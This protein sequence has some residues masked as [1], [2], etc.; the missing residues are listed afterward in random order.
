[1][2]RTLW[3]GALCL[4]AACSDGFSLFGD[5]NMTLA[6]RAKIEH[7]FDGGQ[8]LC[9]GRFV[10]NVPKGTKVGFG[11]SSGAGIGADLMDWPVKELDA[12]IAKMADELR[13]TEHKTELGGLLRHIE[14]DPVTGA[15]IL[16]HRGWA[17]NVWGYYVPAYVPVGNQVYELAG[18]VDVGGGSYESEVARVRAA[19]RRF[20]P[21]GLWEIPKGPGFCAEDL[22]IADDGTPGQEIV[23]IGLVFPQWPDI[24]V[25]ITLNRD[26]DPEQYFGE[27]LLTRM[28]KMEY[29][30]EQIAPELHDLANS[31]K[32]LRKGKAELGNWKGQ[33]WLAT[34]APVR[35]H[36]FKFE[37]PHEPGNPLKPNFNLELFS[38]LKDGERWAVKPTLS[39]E[40]VVALYEHLMKHIVPREGAAAR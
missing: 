21:R 37:A 27:D 24:Q 39:D 17:E 38:G 16:A 25:S 32:V 23:Q 22:F 13:H 34:M 31:V 3:L 28:H 30:N 18:G 12:R 8:P 40:E 15:W 19:A 6:A 4:L 20:H 35:A 5:S 26:A 9:F 33:E 11:L 14:H 29:A 2:R 10:V 1:M 36:E 7:A